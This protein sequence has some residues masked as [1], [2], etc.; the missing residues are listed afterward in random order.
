[1]QT[2]HAASRV[3][4]SYLKSFYHRIAARR[5][6]NRAALAVAH[7]QIISIYDELHFDKIY[8]EVGENIFDHLNQKALQQRLIKRLE[9]LG[10]KVLLQ[11]QTET[12]TDCTAS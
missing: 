9:N 7:K 6:K 11:S 12:E 5:G 4:G 3:K 2:A 8:I 1:M 10:C